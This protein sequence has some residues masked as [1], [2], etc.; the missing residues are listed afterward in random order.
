MEGCATRIEK[1]PTPFFLS[2]N[3]S[4][5]MELI[6]GMEHQQEWRYSPYTWHQS[7]DQATVLL[8]VPSD[9]AEED[10]SV[11]I[12]KDYIVAGI[13]G[14]A[15]IIKGKLYAQIEPSSSWQ[16]EFQALQLRP[17]PRE[18]TTSTTSVTSATS[19]STQSSYAFISDPEISSSFAASL[20]N[21]DTLPSPAL[22]SSPSL[23][24]ER[25]FNLHQQFSPPSYSQPVSRRHSIP[26]STSS[27]ASIDTSNH[28]VSGGYSGKLLTLHLEKSQAVIWPALIVGPVPDALE[29]S[30]GY[31]NSL[32][33]IEVEQ[34]YN[35]DPTS[36]TL[37]AL[38]LIDVQKDTVEAFE[39]FL[40]AWHF[41]HA[42]TA[43]MKLVS[44]YFPIHSSFSILD[45]DSEVQRG[46]QAYYLQSI[47]GRSGLARLYIEAGMLYLEGTASSLVSSSH[48]SLASIR[49]PLQPYGSIVGGGTEAWRRDR[50][51][52]SRFFERA[53]ALQ[54]GL[55]I[56]ALPLSGPGSA[57][58]LKLELELQVQM[59]SIDLDG[60]RRTDILTDA[61][62]GNR[63][64]RQKENFARE[65][66]EKSQSAL[67][68]KTSSD[69][70]SAWYMLL[71]GLV[72]AGTAL[73]VVGVVGVLSLSWSRRNQGS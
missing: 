1:R 72:G 29:S 6:H 16:L 59:P 2:P 10:V 56:P 20:E 4:P 39:C 26:S 40:R 18:R 55:D 47:G 71:P 7:H 48:S 50:V 64:R 51:A 27:F 37:V 70:D 19:G 45:T 57:E 30:L 15:P 68:E 25:S 54:P 67:I 35:M 66:E 14:Q 8:M 43:T 3:F 33:G 38:E 65:Q 21:H 69:M 52:A 36:L 41:A 17:S 62:G 23:S 11:A 12:E 9:T 73:V 13:S 31:P 58:E 61:H 34:K 42:P 53:R 24:S 5:S 63:R 28:I 22:S 44:C 49:M 46:T 32:V 60:T